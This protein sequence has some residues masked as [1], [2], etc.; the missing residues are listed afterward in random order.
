MLSFKL[1]VGFLFAS[2][3][4]AIVA[5]GI[6][7]IGNSQKSNDS[8][9]LI[10]QTHD[11]I[12]V[13][14][15]LS[16]SYKEMQ[17][18]SNSY[19]VTSDSIYLPHYFEARDNSLEHLYGLHELTR[20]N[21]KQQLRADSLSSSLDMLITF[22]DSV[23]AVSNSPSVRHLQVRL[24]Q[25]RMYR[26]KIRSL[27]V[28]MK[29][30]EDR[31]MSERVRANAKNNE[32]FDRTFSLL[33]AGIGAFL[34]TTFFSIRYNFNKRIK[35]EEELKTVNDLFINLFY[36]SPMGLAIFDIDSGVILDCNNAYCE[37]INHKREDVI[38]RTSVELG[39]LESSEQYNEIIKRIKEYH[40]ERDVEL[41]LAPKGKD[42]I[43]VSIAMQFIDYKGRQRVLSAILDMTSQ[44][45]AE[46]DI[47][48]ALS[49]ELE[50]S[51]LKS[52]FITLASHEFRT[53]L[54]SILS[55]SSLIEKYASGE[56]D[57]KIKKHVS[58]IS[59]SVK[60][61]TSLLD[62]FLSLTKIE[63]GKIV[64]RPEYVD[65]NK[66]LEDLCVSFRALTKTGQVITLHHSGQTDV[67]IDPGLLSNILTNLISNAIKYSGENADIV[68]ECHANHDLNLS[69]SDNGIGISKEDQGHLFERFFRAS[70]AESIQGTGLGLHITKHYID[71]LRGSIMIESE[72]GK[73]TKVTISF[74]NAIP[75]GVMDP[76]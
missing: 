17:L 35:V 47:R 30:E 33:L 49:S 27:L 50:L 9:Q 51:K 53:P 39:L 19:F 5:L 20:E 60:S 67:Y 3:V 44:K 42:P 57:E 36:D 45:N 62:E 54:T 31:L 48:R 10:Q 69:V 22:T 75:E 59:A 52:N 16:T 37:L 55:S 46:E 24:R 2:I 13:I 74:R 63:E 73:G 25:N 15:E 26:E 21:A 66:F 7:S 76:L 65:I 28:S 68:I 56:N 43:W 71:M 11:V 40:I 58:R 14:Q 70:N 61:L 32:A 41:R 72:L 1:F 4:I 34:I 29:A 8:A 64:A 38:G 12:G 6:F 23:L 18:E